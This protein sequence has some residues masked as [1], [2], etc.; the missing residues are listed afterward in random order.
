MKRL[1]HQR[2]LPMLKLLGA[3]LAHAVSEC[4]GRLVWTKLTREDYLSASASDA[5]TE[6]LIDI[7]RT[8]QDCEICALFRPTER[9]RSK[10]SLRCESPHAV[11]TIAAEFGGGGHPYAAGF[12]TDMP[13]DE[14]AKRT[15]ERLRK[16]VDSR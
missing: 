3:A 11:D 10:G 8:A 2:S 4:D 1:F 12:S 9:G 14:A 16:L 7:L 13:L 6:G 15:L 5:D